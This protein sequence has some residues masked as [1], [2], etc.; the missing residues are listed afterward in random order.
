[1][2]RSQSARPCRNA[3]PIMTTSERAYVIPQLSHLPVSTGER[4]G[5]AYS[6]SQEDMCLCGRTREAVLS[7]DAEYGRSKEPD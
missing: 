2:D 3:Q 7:L 4:S 6:A 1:M 5:E